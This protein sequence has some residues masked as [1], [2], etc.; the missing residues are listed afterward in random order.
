MHRRRRGEIIG[1]SVYARDP[2]C[3]RMTDD[4]DEVVFT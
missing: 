2:D 4:D 3:D 1:N